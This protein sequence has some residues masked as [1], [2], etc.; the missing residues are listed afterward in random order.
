MSELDGREPSTDAK[1]VLVKKPK[2]EEAAK[3]FAW[4]KEA[5]A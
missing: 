4:F 2:N 1:V 3:Q 5:W